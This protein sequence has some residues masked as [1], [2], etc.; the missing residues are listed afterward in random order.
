MAKDKTSFILYT[1]LIHTVR[2][3]SDEQSGILFKHILSYVN[4]ENPVINDIL[5][6][7]VFE[8]IKQKLKR[9][10]RSYEAMCLKNKGNGLKGGRPKSKA[11]KPTGLN[12]NPNNPTE[13]DNDNDN[14]NDSDIGN[15]KKRRRRTPFVI[16]EISEVRKYFN[17]NGYDPNFGESRWHYYNDANWFDSHGNAVLN[18]KQKMRSVWFKDEH[19]KP[20]IKHTPYDPDKLR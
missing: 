19:L 6:E 18:W 4:D 5:I 17:D 16:P 20:I 3:L 1:D 11:K 12:G 2:K 7:L 10:L 9:D 13:P 8:P 15:E 14:D